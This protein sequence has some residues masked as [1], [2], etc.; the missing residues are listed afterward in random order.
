MGKATERPRETSSALARARA[1]ALVDVDSAA[2]AL[3]FGWLID[4]ARRQRDGRGVGEKSL[5]RRVPLHGRDVGSVEAVPS[6]RKSP[7]KSRTR[8]DAE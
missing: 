2:L 3:E 7:R 8:K 4:A 1:A 6:P 5:W